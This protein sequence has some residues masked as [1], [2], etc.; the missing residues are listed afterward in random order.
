MRDHECSQIVLFHDTLGHFQNLSC[1]LGVKR[2]GMLIQKQELRLLQGCHQQSQCLTLATGQQANLRCHTFFQTKI[3][4][5]QL[6]FI[7]LTLCLGDTGT[8]CSRLA[9]AGSQR[10]ILLD[11]HIGSS[12]HHGILEHT[13]DVLCPLMLR[14]VSNINAVNKDLAF[15]HAVNTGNRVHKGRLTGTVTAN[16]SNEIAGI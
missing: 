4:N 15:I 13:T 9:P 12:A 8:E 3:Q 14:Q 2:S 16:D 5:L 10:Q 7:L 11:P 6:L 1:G